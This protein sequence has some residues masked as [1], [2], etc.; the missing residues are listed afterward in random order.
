MVGGEVVRPRGWCGT[1]GNCPGGR[2][3]RRKGSRTEA[4]GDASFP[5][6]ATAAVDQGG[7]GWH[8]FSVIV[9][10]TVAQLLRI[11]PVL[12]GSLAQLVGAFVHVLGVGKGV[13]HRMLA[14]GSAPRDGRVEPDPCPT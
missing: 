12:V 1:V 3:A 13:G 10:G 14:L 6:A 4:A 7:S 11:A 2:L 9:G 8:C 5:G